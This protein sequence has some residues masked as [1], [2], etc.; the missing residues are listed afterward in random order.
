M[1]QFLI[2]LLIAS[3]LTSAA[4]KVLG[5]IQRNGA[6]DTYATHFDS[7]QKGGFRVV[8]TIAER[9]SIPAQLRKEGMQVAVQ[10][11]H[12]T[13]ELS[14]GIANSFW[15]VVAGGG[16]T[17]QVVTDGSFYSPIWGRGKVVV[18]P[19]TAN[20]QAVGLG[21]DIK[22]DPK[23]GLFVLIY[24]NY[25][26]DGTGHDIYA[27]TSRDLITW[28]TTPILVFPRSGV[29][30]QFDKS[31]VTG[32]KLYYD[33]AAGIWHLYYI[34]F[35]ANGFEYGQ[36]KTG[37]ATT[38]DILNPSAY[39]RETS[40]ILYASGWLGSTD[41][42]FTPDVVKVRDSFYLFFNGGPYGNEHFGVAKS[43]TP[44]GPFTVTS[45]PLIPA[46]QKAAPWCEDTFFSDPE[47][48]HYG[49]KW[50]CMFWGR[51]VWVGT[52]D[53]QSGIMWTTDAEFPGNWRGYSNYMDLGIDGNDKRRMRP[54]RI[55]KDGQEYLFYNDESRILVTTAQSTFLASP[56][57]N[58]IH[59]GQSL[60]G[61][62]SLVAAGGAKVYIN[63]RLRVGKTD[64][65]NSEGSDFYNYQV[66]S[67]RPAKPNQAFVF[68][69]LPTGTNTTATIEVFDTSDETAIT[70]RVAIQNTPTC[71]TIGFSNNF[72]G[73]KYIRWVVGSNSDRM[74]LFRTGN[75]AIGF[76]HADDGINKLQVDG[77]AWVR[78]T[79]KLAGRVFHKT[80]IFDEFTATTTSATPT[81]A[82][83]LA[84]DDN[85]AYS[86]EYT[87][88]FWDGANNKTGSLISKACIKKLSGTV[89][90]VGQEDIGNLLYE[91]ASD[92]GVASGISANS[93][94][95]DFRLSG[96]A[97]RSLYWNVNYKLYKITP[98]L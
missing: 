39:T 55:T 88:T 43:A 19:G 98:S 30:G 48:F 25:S 86:L 41:Y 16:S 49:N 20:G 87:S 82:L 21:Y 28:S 80:A 11:T 84:L 95:L 47:V 97:G 92:A 18:N 73:N 22:F 50:Y 31:G 74:R 34:G 29:T 40:P 38:T 69:A 79:A 76:E 58:V 17:A 27:V 54:K 51:K 90:I 9:D 77:N 44:G 15:A 3:S 81:T 36:S 33:E 14:G 65:A 52:T 60:F 5:G 42:I 71:A 23:S 10:A 24:A 66:L 78:D 89:T 93:G 91:D 53:L 70:G 56:D 72:S 85:S 61:D 46:G 67:A 59:G 13:F 63:G 94:S 7:L 8:A 37:H 12:T 35:P 83:T 57:N 4:Q 62:T 1:K 96:V 68:R 2:L 75:L 45:A 6:A 26:N 64:L 32:P